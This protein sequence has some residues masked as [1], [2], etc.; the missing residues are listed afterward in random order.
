MTNSPANHEKCPTLADSCRQPCNFKSI[1]AA[2]S[3]H[4]NCRRSFRTFKTACASKL[5]QNNCTSR[6]ID[7]SQLRRESEQLVLAATLQHKKPP[8]AQLEQE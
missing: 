4:R 1:S 8:L 5:H 3:C 7:I 6:C 2:S